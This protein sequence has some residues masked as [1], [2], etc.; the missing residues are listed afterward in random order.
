MKEMRSLLLLALAGLGACAT[1]GA[2][3][4]SLHYVDDALVYS[5]PPSALAYEAYLR[6][7]VALSSEPPRLEQA[8]AEIEVA[9]HYDRRA[10]HLWSTQAEIAALQG[11]DEAAVNSAERALAL[12]P[13]YAPARAVLTDVRGGP[14]AAHVPG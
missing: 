9:L 1:P 6:A 2:S 8:R 10:P 13:G 14:R 5:N 3:A 11:D 7:R 12:R 4:R